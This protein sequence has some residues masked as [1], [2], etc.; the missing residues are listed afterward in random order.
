VNRPLLGFSVLAAPDNPAQRDADE[1]SAKIFPEPGQ[2]CTREPISAPATCGQGCPRSFGFGLAALRFCAFSLMRP[3]LIRLYFGMVCLP[4]VLTLTSCGLLRFSHSQPKAEIKS[5]Q[6][7][8]NEAATAVTLTVLQGQVMRV[9]DDYVAKVA[10]SADE[11]GAQAATPEARLAALKWKLGQATSA[12]I[13]A[14]GPNPALNA[15]DLLVLVTLARMVIEEYGVATYGDNILPLLETQRNLEANAWTLAGGVMKP[16]Q[17]QELK[18][19]IQEWRRKN[20]K[21]VYIGPIR[22][23]EFVAALGKTPTPKTTAPT[24][25][26]S[27]LFLDPMAG[28]D[29]TA[30]AIEETRRLGERAMYYTQRMPMLLSWQTEVLAYQLAVQ[31]ESRQMLDDATRLAASAEI[32]AKTAQQLPQLVNDQREAAIRQVFD[33]LVAEEKKTRDL[34]AEARQTISSASEM[35]A[36][37]N[38]TIK[39]LDGFVHFV[40]PTNTSQAVVSTNSKPFNVLDYGMAASQ[41]GAAAS[42]LNALLASMNQSA[43]QVARLRERTTEDAKA[44]VQHAFW[45]GLVLILIL[46][47]GSVLA[48]LVYRVLANKLS[49]N[50]RKLSGP[51]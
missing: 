30:A 10:Q 39:S 38:A 42:E 31:P 4:L 48:G 35:S 40:T 47:I 13:D 50:G 32:F 11:F 36:S 34:L 23:R 6:L 20:P 44:L 28:L 27:L 26:F 1:R 24:S 3:I 21:Q 46:L 49:R 33:G 45:L 43:P 9:A 37:V 18:D 8:T 51:E 5:I 22:F 2:P 41:V 7:G 25:I 17:E 14:S 19:L 12:Y 29:P 16:A 15:L